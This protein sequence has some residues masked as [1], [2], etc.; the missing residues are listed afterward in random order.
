MG[1]LYEDKI[2]KEVGVVR[3]SL[4]DGR[5]GEEYAR[6]CVYLLLVDHLG[7]VQMLEVLRHDAQKRRTGKAKMQ[8][9][10]CGLFLV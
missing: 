1:G 4:C 7:G 9:Q 3:A 8:M 2:R 6:R 5:T 10:T